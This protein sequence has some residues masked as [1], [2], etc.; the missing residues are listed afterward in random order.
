M[1]NKKTLALFDFCD[2]LIGMQTANRFVTLAYQKNKRFSAVANE[3]VRVLGRK[4]GLLFGYRHKKWQLKQIKGLSLEDME[5]I[6]KEYVENFLIPKENKAVVEKML[7]HKAQ[8]DTVVIVSGGFS[9]YIKHYAKKYDIDFVVA[10]DLEV[11]DGVYTGKIAGLDC[12]GINKIKK[13][14]DTIDLDQ[15]DMDNSYAY[16]DHQSDIPL[17]CLVGRPY[18]VDF[19]QDI[20]WAKLMG[21]EIL[22]VK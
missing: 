14:R 17:L 20:E 6:V 1:Q 15:F 19:G 13:L 8:G 21:Y 22:N 2:T 18:V 7:W 10:T 3:F 12:M 5:E 11:C 9:V 16:S 4:S